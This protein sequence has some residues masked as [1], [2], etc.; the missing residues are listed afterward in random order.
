MN[1]ANR[2]TIARIFLVPVVMF[3]LLVHYNFG[4]VSLAGHVLTVNEIVAALIFVVAAST[5]GLDGYIA[6]KRRIVTNFGKFLDPLADKLLIS[7]VLISLVEMHR[8]EAWEAIVIISREFA[9][10]G[11]RLVAAAEGTVIAASRM[12]KLKTVTQIVA[13]V[14]LMM[15][16]LPF[17]YVGIPVAAWIMYLAVLITVISGIDYFVKNRHVIGFGKT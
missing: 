13:V 5:D 8:V 14:A 11:L 9:V 2:I 15:N 6:R 4:R 3:F 16:N 10:T 1:L 7:A 17:A 12:G